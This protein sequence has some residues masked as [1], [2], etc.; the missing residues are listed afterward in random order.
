MKK[1]VVFLFILFVGLTAC[2]KNTENAYRLQGYFEGK[3][4]KDSSIITLVYPVF[5][6]SLWYN[7]TDSSLV[8][9]NQFKF[10]GYIEDLTTATIYFDDSDEFFYPVELFIEASDMEIKIDVEDTYRTTF[11][12]SS[13]DG[14]N[15][16]L[17]SLVLK[18]HRLISNSF[19]STIKN[20][21][22]LNNTE[23]LLVRDS[24]IQ[25]INTLKTE[26]NTYS[27][28]LDSVRFNFVSLNIDTDIATSLL[29][30]S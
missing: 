19:K 6:D 16:E 25:N 7:K 21:N 22:L 12:G 20:I 28:R 10:Q 23:N 3:A 1:V 26:R 8:I 27:Y 17:S 29:W 14:I 4:V 13:I 11:K 24:L 9:N 18:Y 15:S 2:Q 5:K 30:T